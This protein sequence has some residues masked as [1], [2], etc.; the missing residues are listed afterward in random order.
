MIGRMKTACSTLLAFGVAT[1]ATAAPTLDLTVRAAHSGCRLAAEVVVTARDGSRSTIVADARGTARVELPAAA[2]DVDLTVAAAGHRPL[3]TH[4][5]VAA[6][7]LPVT[8]WLD[9]TAVTTAVAVDDQ[10]A[11]AAGRGVVRGWVWDAVSGEPLA[12]AVVSLV[13][14]GWGGIT[15]AAGEFRFELEVATPVSDALPEVDALVVDAPGHV[16]EVREGFFL[17]RGVATSIVDLAPGQGTTV[18]PATHKMLDLHAPT[19]LGADGSSP[20]PVVKAIEPHDPPASIRLGTSCSCTTCSSV[21][22]LSF[23][24]YVQRG[25]NDEWIAS[26]A[27]DSLRAGAVAYRSY[28]AWY[29]ANPISPASYDI[30]STTCCQV[31][32]SDTHANAVAAAIATAGFMLQRNGVVFR[33]EYSAENNAWDDPGDGHSC[34]NADLSCGDGEAGSPATSWSCLAD[35]LCAGHGCY[36]HGRGMCQWGTSRWAT[37][38]SSWTWIVDHYYNDHGTGTGYRTARMTTPLWIDAASPTPAVVGAGESFTIDVTASNA[39][40]LD[41]GAILIGASLYAA[42]TGYISDPPHDQPVTLAPGSNAV[43]RLFAVP[44]GTPAGAYDLYVSLY[45]DVNGNG[46][47]AVGDLGLVVVTLSQAVTVA[48]TVFADGFESGSTSAWG[49]QEP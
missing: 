13:R 24:T 17:E 49:Y 1:A 33:S 8:V 6:A 36:G 19:Q 18:R 27:P 31:N 9:S 15:D 43:S 46:A 21:D 34:S 47:I 45:Y 7:A 10:A 14:S 5:G 41:H 42:T 11:V 30:C 25:V 39:S 37:A 22:V 38:G 29:V 28:G 2:A 40:E 4:F 16:S 26:W 48:D 35:S 44:A 20:A 3:A 32:T 23:E 12:G